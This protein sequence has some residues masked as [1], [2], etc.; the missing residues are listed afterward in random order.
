M[1]FT[2][3]DNRKFIVALVSVIFAFV[4]ALLGKLTPEYVNIAISV[5]MAFSGANAAEHFA[6]GWA[7]RN[8]G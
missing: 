4:L 3:K 8:G 7:T 6:K 2:L 1:K 5:I